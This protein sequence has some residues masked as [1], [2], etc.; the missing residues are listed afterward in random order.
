MQQLA[1]SALP[2]CSEAFVYRVPFLKARGHGQIVLRAWLGTRS[3]CAAAVDREMS[4][5]LHEE[6]ESTPKSCAGRERR[7]CTRR[8]TC[9]CSHVVEL[10]QQDPS[11]RSLLTA[12]CLPTVPGSRSPHRTTA[13]PTRARTPR[14]PCALPLHPCAAVWRCGSWRSDPKSFH[15]VPSH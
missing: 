11:G 15:G 8:V 5:G 10:R 4:A 14:D 3:R 7:V 9:Q 13:C 6:C 12:G 2:N 1:K